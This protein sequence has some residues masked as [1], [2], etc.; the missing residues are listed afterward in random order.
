MER[1]MTL[2]APLNRN[3]LRALLATAQHHHILNPQICPHCHTLQRPDHTPFLV[4]TPT[5]SVL[6]STYHC[7]RCNA[8]WTET[9]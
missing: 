5:D 3:L 8:I 6:Y 4:H 2:T 7:P 1:R 9:S